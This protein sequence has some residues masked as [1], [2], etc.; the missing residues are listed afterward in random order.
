MSLFYDLFRREPRVRDIAAGEYLFQEGQA[1]QEEMFV[2][3]AGQAKIM[4]GGL[5][6]EEAVAGTI[7]GEMAL[8]E[9]LRERSAT[10]LAETN[11]SFVVIDRRRFRY[12]VTEAPEFAL[13]VMRVLCRRLRGMDKALHQA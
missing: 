8:I 9:D 12:L 10:V 11:C 7:V 13:E 1:C 4:V 3:V 2:L 5:V 6:V